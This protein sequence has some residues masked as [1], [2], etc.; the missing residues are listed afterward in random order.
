MDIEVRRKRILELLAVRKVVSVPELSDYVQ[1]SGATIRRDLTQMEGEGVIIR[2]HGGAR[3]KDASDSVNPITELSGQK[4]MGIYTNEKVAIAQKA[5]EFVHDGDTVYMDSGTTPSY[6]YDYLRD[7]K[8]TI[9]TNNFFIIERIRKSDTAKVI[10]GAG[11]FNPA[12]KHVGGYLYLETIQQFHYTHCFL[13]TNGISL[14]TNQ[15]S[16]STIEAANFKSY[17]MRNS[18]HCYLLA[19]SS[20][21]F[22]KG[23]VYYASIDDFTSIFTSNYQGEYRDDIIPC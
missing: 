22:K 11:E 7:K 4:K 9:V 5:A 20:K 16:A 1:V 13:G 18:D 3:M 8:V 6:L 17:A 23:M 19:D 12:L 14:E 2:V 10:F 15:C 21:F